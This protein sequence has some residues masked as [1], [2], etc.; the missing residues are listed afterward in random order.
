MLW[1]Q[2]AYVTDFEKRFTNYSTGD[3]VLY[4]A[5][6]YVFVKRSVDFVRVM[7]FDKGQLI[8]CGRPADLRNKPDSMFADMASKTPGLRTTGAPGNSDDD[9]DVAASRGF[10]TS[11]ENG[12]LTLCA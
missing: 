10:G 2:L 9:D 6:L 12:A 4:R 3:C 7:V 11:N 8:E 1:V 5:A